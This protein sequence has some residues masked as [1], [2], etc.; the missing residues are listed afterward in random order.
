MKNEKIKMMRENRNT[1]LC[2]QDVQ[3]QFTECSRGT[4]ETVEK[5]LFAEPHLNITHKSAKAN[6]RAESWRSNKILL[7]KFHD[8]SRM[9]FEIE[10]SV[11]LG[12]AE[13]GSNVVVDILHFWEN[14]AEK[15]AWL[16]KVNSRI[17]SWRQS[18]RISIR[19]VRFAKSMLNYLQWRRRKKTKSFSGVC[20]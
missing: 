18:Q 14:C 2:R 10:D 1:F 11:I 20:K 8:T 13:I 15:S 12:V 17:I 19:D 16:N 7:T 4:Q 5:L 6:Q 3:T 9:N